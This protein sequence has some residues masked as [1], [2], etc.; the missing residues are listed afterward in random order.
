MTQP[1]DSVV[2]QLGLSDRE[3]FLISAGDLNEPRGAGDRPITLRFDSTDTRA[4]GFAGCNQYSAA[5]RLSGDSLTF[6]AP[7]AT[8]MFCEGFMEVET[9]LLGALERV[10]RFEVTDST[11]TL[12]SEEGPVARFRAGAPA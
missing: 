8:K 11:L 1:G 4:G 5:Y 6:Q 12:Y 10:R 2:G 9:A 3:W 7:I